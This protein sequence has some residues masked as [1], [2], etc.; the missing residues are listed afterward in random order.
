MA[1]ALEPAGVVDAH[2][3]AGSELAGQRDVVLV[4]RRRIAGPHQ[5]DGADHLA[6]GDQR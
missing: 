4:E 6:A 2:G 1:L 3:R 5:A